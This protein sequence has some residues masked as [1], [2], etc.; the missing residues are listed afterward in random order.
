MKHAKSLLCLLLIFAM[1]FTLLVACKKD[2]GEGGENS[3]SDSNGV[4]TTEINLSEYTMI[5]TLKSGSEIGVAAK[6]FA[7]AATEALGKEFNLKRDNEVE[8]SA[9]T[10]E[11]L[12]GLTNRAESTQALDALGDKFA[13]SIRVVGNKITV[14]GA[15]NELVLKAL[16]I[17][18]VEYLAKMTDGKMQVP[19]D[20]TVEMD[21]HE[22]VKDGK[23]VYKLIYSETDGGTE[24]FTSVRNI[25]KAIDSY[26]TATQIDFE[27]DYRDIEHKPGEKLIVVGNTNYPHS[28]ELAKEIGLFSW[29]MESKDAQI[30]LCAFEASALNIM[31]NEFSSRLQ[32][33]VLLKG[34]DGKKQTIRLCRIDKVGAD[35]EKW[36]T[37]VPLFT[38]GTADAF[39]QIEKGF[40]RMRYT[41]TTKE[42]YDAYAKKL[43]AEGFSLY[44]SNSMDGNVFNTY[45]K[46]DIMLHT[47]YLKNKTVSL[48]ISA[49]SAAPKAAYPLAAYSDGTN[50]ADAKLTLMDMNYRKSDGSFAHNNGMGF[51]FT[52]S[53]GSYVVVDGGHSNDAEKLYNYMKDNNRR[54]DGKIL[55]RAWIITHPDAD[56]YGCIKNFANSYG[57][58]VNPDANVVLEKYVAHYHY[59]SYQ[60]GKTKRTID[61]IDGAV[62]KFGSYQR[63]V[64]LLGQTLYFGEAAFTF[65]GT[66]E[67][68]TA[69][70]ILDTNAQSLIMNVAFKGKKILMMG[71]AVGA[72]ATSSNA[73][74]DE[75]FRANFLQGAH[76]CLNPH[77]GIDNK[78]KP[79]LGVIFCTHTTAANERKSNYAGLIKND[80]MFIVA[81]GGYKTII[82]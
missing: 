6:D 75:A 50:V 4:A 61:G 55:I 18:N 32:N 24:N 40:Y 81:D 34:T 72:M 30:Y 8:A 36:S 47:Y 69:L 67:L 82:E 3:G 13:Y 52:M 10:K 80:S 20:Y 15:T 76:H 53:D 37:P 56:H 65:L 64:P 25:K 44:A 26:A 21:Y 35:K 70:Q 43:A 57:S 23:A 28:K 71:D 48:V 41:Q 59:N 11:I 5:R 78:S 2:E 68:P 60:S 27:Q 46:G 42:A 7:S 49:Q 79:D 33:A 9:D 51:L 38:E 1:T 39:M 62:K 66:T 19:T 73:V 14:M 29:V 74:F 58:R 54:E 12:V 17:L 16:N 45:Y 22:I 63:V 77:S 31:G